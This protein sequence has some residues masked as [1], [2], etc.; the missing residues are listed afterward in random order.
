MS[1]PKLDQPRWSGQWP[2]PHLHQAN[3]IQW[4]PYTPTWCTPWP[5]HLAAR[6]P[7]CLTLQGTLILVC[8]IHLWPCHP[9]SPIMRKVSSCKDHSCPTWYQTSK[10]C[11]CSHN[12][13]SQVHQNPL[14]TWLRSFQINSHGSVD[15]LVSTQ[16]DSVMTFIPSYMPPGSAPSP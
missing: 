4:I 12:G 14:M 13:S 6:W 2:G 11:T 15:S 10:P 5:H 1:L 3:C 9:R 16:Y 7:W 8:Y